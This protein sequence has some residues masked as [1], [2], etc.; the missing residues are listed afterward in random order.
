MFDKNVLKGK[1]ILVTGG[2]SGLG[3]EM[4]RHFVKHGAEVYICGRRENVLKDTAD[5][6][7]SEHGG[8]VNYFPLDIRD[9]MSI[10]ENIENVFNEGP[11]DG[12]VNNAA[13]NFISRTKDLSPNGFNAIAS[14]VF[15]GT[16]YITNAVGKRWLELGHKGSIVSILA[17]W[18]WTGS[19]FVVPSAMS[20]SGINAMTKSLAVEWGPHGI[21]LNSIAPGPFPTEGAWARLMP[22][23]GDKKS[24]ISEDAERSNVPLGRVGKMDELGNLATFLM[25]DGCEYLTGQTIAIDGAQYITGGGTFSM[26]SSFK[27]E[28]WDAIK[29]TIKGSNEKDKKQR[30]V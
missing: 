10:E 28:D 26:M 19:P 13:G 7:M 20:K 30:T 18:V 8:K 24:D 15:H 25:A 5:E 14:I 27:D 4:T 23:T 29:N 21:R 1:R 16:F 12:L 11:L 6:I 9:A 3:K 2:G 22:Q 17:T